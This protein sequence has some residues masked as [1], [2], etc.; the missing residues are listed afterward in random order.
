MGADAQEKNPKKEAAEVLKAPEFGHYHEVLRWQARDP[1]K[2][3]E[4]KGVDLSAWHG[5]GYAIAKA[6]EVLLWGI[7][8]A[9]VAYA[10]WW[11]AQRLP[12]GLAAPREAYRPP[13]A[14]FGM[15]LAPEK[16]PPDV[17]GAAMALA[18][19]GKLREALSLLYRGALSELVHKR[20][21]ELL[22][23]HTEGE[24]VQLAA[25]PYF[26]ALVDAWR[27]SAYASRDPSL[28]ELE[29]LVSRYKEA[30]A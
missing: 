22:S 30:F 6:A 21:I 12:R 1:A 19:D 13:P 29:R 10:L 24:A 17:A 3:R 20:G 16:L 23:S 25:L 15:E 18:R 2:P 9:A 8:I 5:I 14:L 26:G 11:I 4:T 7:A 27:R 28:G